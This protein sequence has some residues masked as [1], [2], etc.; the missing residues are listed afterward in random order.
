MKWAAGERWEAD[1]TGRVPWKKKANKLTD[2][3]I[4]VVELTWVSN[5][6]VEGVVRPPKGSQAK[7]TVK[8]TLPAFAMR[9]RVT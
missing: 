9:R 5:E 4:E 6:V 8:C 1:V 7:S 2:P 3:H